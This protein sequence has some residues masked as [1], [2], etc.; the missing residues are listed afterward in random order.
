MCLYKINTFY[1]T[2]HY[3]IILI[4][5]FKQKK[6]ILLLFCKFYADLKTIFNFCIINNPYKSSII[7][8]PIPL[9]IFYKSVYFKYKIN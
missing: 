4:N 7:I 9:P 6:P 2:I 8:S 5:F 1:K 3:Y